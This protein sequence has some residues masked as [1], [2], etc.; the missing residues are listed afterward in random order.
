LTKITRHIRTDERV[1]AALSLL[2]PAEVRDDLRRR[3]VPAKEVISLFELDHV[4][5]HTWAEDSTV[6]EWWNLT[7]LEKHVHREK[8]RIDQGKIAKVRRRAKREALEKAQGK[9]QEILLGKRW[10][11]APSKP[12]WKR[13][14][15]GKTVRVDANGKEL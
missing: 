4:Q 2:L 8:T 3:K 13:K 14:I 11:K 12:K 15:N 1:A 7:W 6:N 5:F 10:T 9:V